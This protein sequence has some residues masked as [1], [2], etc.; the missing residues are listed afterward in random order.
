VILLATQFSKASEQKQRQIYDLYL[1]NVHQNRINN[2]DIV[3]SSAEFVVGPYLQNRD[4]KVLVDLAKSDNLWQKRV[5]ILAT[6][7][8]IKRGDPSVTLDIID[9]VL[10]DPNDLIQKA[11]GWML[12][13]IGKQVDEEILTI[14]LD[15]HAH[16]MPRTTLRY[17]I[18]RLSPKQKAHYMGLK[19]RN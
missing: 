1:L 18:E 12:R 16:D 2:W 11:T 14:F 10:H 9:I 5:A 19:N 6:F 17:A 13:E 4:K 7:H 8:Y 15:K 3:D